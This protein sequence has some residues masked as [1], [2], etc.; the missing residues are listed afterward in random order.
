MTAAQKK[1]PVKKIR[2]SATKKGK[3]TKAKDK[4]EA[5]GLLHQKQAVDLRIKGLSFEKIG[6]AIGLTSSGAFRAYKRALEKANAEIVET[7]S[8]FRDIELARLDRMTEV[9]MKS[10]KVLEE[11]I[12]RDGNVQRG[13]KGLLDTMNQ[14]L[15]IQ[16]R[17]SRLLGLDAASKF[18]IA[19]K[20]GQPIM[21]EDARAKL[22][23]KLAAKTKA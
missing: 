4:Q 19:G 21:I 3:S 7:A 17:R 9:L 10:L 6:E 15:K 2:G 14:L 5:L 20:D 1:N 23:E 18:E 16:E 8:D 12:E 22:F 13:R 11:E